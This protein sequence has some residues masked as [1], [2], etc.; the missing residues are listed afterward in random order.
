MM[1]NTCKS[2]ADRALFVVKVLVD[3]SL[4]QLDYKPYN[5]TLLMLLFTRYALHEVATKL[6]MTVLK[7]QCLA[8]LLTDTENMI[9]AAFS[10]G[11]TLQEVLGL[12]SRN[13]EK[14]A[15]QAKAI[16]SDNV[17]QVVFNHVLQDAKCPP[18]LLDMVISTLAECLEPG[19]WQEL[20][21]MVNHRISLLIIQA[22]L[23][24]RQIKME[25]MQGLDVKP[26]GVYTDDDS[27]LFASDGHVK[28]A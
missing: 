12:D 11:L 1:P 28:S 9:L 27:M 17:V 8:R 6:G 15:T 4:A 7:Q 21:L 24:R 13:S 18:R 20:T 3:Y 26:E 22:M 14:V 25:E 16:A 5:N 10:E 23:E 2:Y 19:L